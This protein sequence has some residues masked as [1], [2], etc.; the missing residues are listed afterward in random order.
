MF[1]Y[2][3]F[4]TE[5]NYFTDVNHGEEYVV[6]DGEV[7]GL[8]KETPEIRIEQPFFFKENGDPYLLHGHQELIG[9]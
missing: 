4:L 5:T 9:D 7:F 2:F 6:P 1:H 8:V 3:S